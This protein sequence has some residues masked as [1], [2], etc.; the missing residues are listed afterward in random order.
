MA[1]HVPAY[2][3]VHPHGTAQRVH[4]CITAYATGLEV[5]TEDVTTM[6]GPE[7]RITTGTWVELTTKHGERFRVP[8]D[9]LVVLA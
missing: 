3:A 9:H 5:D 7:R 1:H 8:A 4:V 6:G 2:R